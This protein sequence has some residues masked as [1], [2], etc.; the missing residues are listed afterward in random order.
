MTTGTNKYI[1]KTNIMKEM[2]NKNNNKS[3]S[4]NEETTFGP[5][6]IA[7]TMIT[8]IGTATANFSRQR[9]Q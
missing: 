9:Q 8:S 2:H 4:T 7:I 1:G 3:H 5:N 6:A